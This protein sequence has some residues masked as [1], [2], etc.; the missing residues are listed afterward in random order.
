MT[1]ELVKEDETRQ[2]LGFVEDDRLEK[3]LE[4]LA[5]K[6]CLPEEWQDALSQALKCETDKWEG[7]VVYLGPLALAAICQV[8]GISVEAYRLEE[9][10]ELEGLGFRV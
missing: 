5:D 6:N 9:L 2:S 8:Y 4:E 3:Q 10:E 1:P 7:W